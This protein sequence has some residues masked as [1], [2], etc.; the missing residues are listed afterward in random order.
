MEDQKHG[1]ESVREVQKTSADWIEKQML[2][3]VLDIL[4][5]KGER[6]QA[7]SRGFD[8]GYA[9][10]RWDMLYLRRA[11]NRNAQNV[12]GMLSKAN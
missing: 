2:L 6:A 5:E 3:R 1:R 4:K 12:R 8:M 11:Y 7:K 9:T 10:L